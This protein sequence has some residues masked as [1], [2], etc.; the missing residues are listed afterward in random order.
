[1][2]YTL[3]HTDS[4]RHTHKRTDA[5]RRTQ[6]HK[7][8]CVWVRVFFCV[9]VTVFFCV[10]VRVFFCVWVR[11]FFWQTVVCVWVRVFLGT[12]KSAH[13]RANTRGVRARG[14]DDARVECF[15]H[16]RVISKRSFSLEITRENQVDMR[17]SPP[18]EKTRILRALVGRF[19]GDGSPDGACCARHNIGGGIGSDCQYGS[20]RLPRGSFSPSAP[21]WLQVLSLTT[22]TLGQW[23]VHGISF[24]AKHSFTTFPNTGISRLETSANLRNMYTVRFPANVERAV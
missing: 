17:R 24:C 19:R 22:T 16:L 5:H 9:W 13:E 4:Q 2:D 21:G 10:W 8:V 20:I 23:H 14:S 1:V 15:S 7:T 12:R 6:V 18:L 11:V 3:T